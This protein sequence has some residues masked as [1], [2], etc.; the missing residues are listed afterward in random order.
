VEEGAFVDGGAM[1]TRI[2]NSDSSIIR[3][4]E[5]SIPGE[6][7]LQNAMAAALAAQVHGVTPAFLRS[8]LRNFKGV[9]HRQ[10]FVREIGGISYVND[11]KATTVDALAVALKSYDRPI[12]LIMGGKDKGNDYSAVADLVRTK[13]KT[14]IATGH[15]ADI[16]ERFFAPIVPVETVPTVGTDIPNLASMRKAVQAATSRARQGDVVL[17][18]PACTSFDWFTDYE[19]RGRIFK[20]IVNGLE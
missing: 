6:H 5:L 19:E 9:E 8:T 20:S 14:I 13:V 11:S 10:E 3:T 18:S 16:I 1:V 4:S 12:V 15:S 17:L 7:N 2:G